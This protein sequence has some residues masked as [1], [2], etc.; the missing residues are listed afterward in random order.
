MP[1]ENQLCWS[2]VICGLR[3]AATS[4]QLT[5]AIAPFIQKPA[6]ED[7]LSTLTWAPNA[8]IL[9]MWRAADI[10]SGVSDIEIYP[11]LAARNIRLMLNDYLHL[12]LF[13]FTDG[14]AFLTSANITGSG[15]GTSHAPNAEVGATL[16]INEGHTPHIAALLAGSVVVTQEIY[17]HAK[18]YLGQNPPSP[19]PLPPLTFPQVQTTLRQ[20]TLL[21]ISPDVTV[22]WG[23]YLARPLI[24]GQT[25]VNLAEALMDIQTLQIPPGLT[26]AQFDVFVRDALNRNHILIKLVEGLKKDRSYCFGQVLSRMQRSLAGEPAVPR[27]EL[28]PYAR[29]LYDWLPWL[30]S[31]ISWDRPHHSMVL[32]FRS[33][34]PGQASTSL[35]KKRT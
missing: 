25:N 28:K 24:D 10:V 4:R 13:L 21:P 11:L 5:L 1:I 32:R 23:V 3:Q 20:R 18:A 7:L 22:L 34:Q 27:A 6:L 33:T 15:M 17:T 2:P 9:T 31:N 12:K 14:S 19:R 8:T 30:Y 16:T 35:T 26:R 29:A